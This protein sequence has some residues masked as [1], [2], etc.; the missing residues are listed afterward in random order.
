MDILFNVEAFLG[1][2]LVSLALLEQK[3][4][5]RTVV[6]ICVGEGPTGKLGTDADL[7]ETHKRTVWND[8][9]DKRTTA[10]LTW[11]ACMSRGVVSIYGGA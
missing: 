9:Y 2:G 6:E 4:E 1:N 10:I 5:E 8:V 11:L 3:L 7:L